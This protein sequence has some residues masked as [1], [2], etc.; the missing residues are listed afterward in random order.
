MTLAGTV[1][2]GDKRT[3][4]YSRTNYII[5]SPSRHA[6]SSNLI[7]CSELS[8]H[9]VPLLCLSDRPFTVLGTADAV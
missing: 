2:R 4:H 3:A 6:L 8:K 7:I 1:M 5:N 9:A